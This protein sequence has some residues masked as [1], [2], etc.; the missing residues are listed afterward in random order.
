MAKSALLNNPFVAYFYFLILGLSPFFFTRG[1]IS[2]NL[3]VQVI[4]GLII[5]LLIIIKIFPLFLDKNKFL[6]QIVG[7]SFVVI[8]INFLVITTGGLSS[9]FLI[10][11]H[12]FSI[13]I[14]FLIS[15]KIAVSF[16]GATITL[17]AISLGLD[18][19]ARVLILE[20]PV[21]AILY[22][23]AYSA[24]VPFSFILAKEYKFKDELARLLEK[25]IATSKTQEEELLQNIADAVLVIDPEFNLVY[26]NTAAANLF[27]FAKEIWGRVLFDVFAFKDKDGRAVLAYSLPLRAT[28]NSK[29]AANIDVLQI[30]TKSKAFI[31]VSLKILP[32]LGSEGPLGLVLIFK[33]STGAE[34]VQKKDISTANAALN[35]LLAI[36]AKQ[37]MQFLDLEKKVG[38]DK[39]TYELKVQNSDLV[40]LAG[41]F[42]YALKLDTG[43]VGAIFTLVDIGKASE[44]AVVWAKQKASQFSISFFIK[45]ILKEELVFPKSKNIQ[46]EKRVFPEVYVLGDSMWIED[47][48]KRILEIAL[49]IAKAGSEV[50]FELLKA[51]EL[52]KINIYC[53][54]IKISTEDLKGLFEKFYGKTSIFKELSS[55][56]GLGGYIAKNL[57]NRMG[58]TVD[59]GVDQSTSG[60][61][62]GITFGV[63]EI[64]EQ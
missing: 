21:A 48:L 45:Q 43:E 53:A 2:L 42:I 50:S 29:S 7:F 27:G 40:N 5:V 31:R 19:T 33:S 24:M 58:G 38:K 46:I 49:T 4:W 10:L 28:L 36:L 47:S 62:F 8:F 59:V 3:L 16:I 23:V 34:N 60:V 18:K 26:S 32:L 57:I 35:R 12:F 17:L 54:Q 11:T 14:A 52:V 13:A 41:D 25:Q 22:L 39:G 20:T 6:I 63:T 51:N 9:S 61:T 64:K 30:S 55:T 56:S 1:H 15:P 37:K 44:R